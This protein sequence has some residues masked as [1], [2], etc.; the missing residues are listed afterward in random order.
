MTDSNYLT[1]SGWEKERENER[2]REMNCYKVTQLG[3]RLS[4]TTTPHCRHWAEMRAF[5]P[6]VCLPAC[7]CFLIDA[8]LWGPHVLASWHRL[9]RVVSDCNG[10]QWSPKIFI[11]TFCSTAQN[12]DKK[13]SRLL[14]P[15][16]N[17]IL[18]WIIPFPQCIFIWIYNLPYLVNGCTVWAS[19]MGKCLYG[20]QN[21]QKYSL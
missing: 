13:L 2:E 12:Y 7:M 15:T 18:S 8:S 4:H 14:S 17:V 6:F 16:C 3:L 1:G 10:L 11:V 20:L 19:R 21:L 5:C 9:S